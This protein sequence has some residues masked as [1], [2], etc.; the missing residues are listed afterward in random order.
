MSL[1]APSIKGLIPIDKIPPALNFA[2]KA[3]SDLLDEIFYED[4]VVYTSQYGEYG[5]Y[6]L[7]LVLYTKLGLTFPGGFALSLNPDIENNLRTLIPISFNYKWEALRYV[8]KLDLENFSPTPKGFFDVL[9]KIAAPKLEEL[10]AITLEVFL[11][12]G[13]AIQTFISQINNE[14]SKGIG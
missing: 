6:D 4:L 3:I 2:E 11:P 9:K 14:Y 10:L 1:F 5:Y 13:N 12:G 8:N 7:T